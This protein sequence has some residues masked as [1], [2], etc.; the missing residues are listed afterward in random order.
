MTHTGIECFLAIC[1]HKTGN[2]AAQALFI[3]QPSL[4]A[5]LTV[6]EKE[7]GKQLFYRRKGSREMVLTP[8]GEEFYHLALQYEAVIDKM[9]NLG[10]SPQT[11]LRISCFNSLGTYL[12]P[13]V[14]Q[15]FLQTNPQISL[16]MQD[17][18]IVAASQSVLQGETD[19]AF[20]AGSISDSRL[21]QIPVFSEPMQVICSSA[22][23]LQTPA[24]L[25]ELPSQ[26]EVYVQWSHNFAQ[27]HQ[28]YLGDFHPQLCVSIMAQLRQFLEQKDRWAIVP[29]SVAKGLETECSI[30]Y[31][32][33]DLPLP[34]REVSYIINTQ[35][36]VPAGGAF[37]DCLRQVLM[38]YPEITVL[39]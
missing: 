30:R 13:A 14:Y 37:L 18:E 4:S 23:Q 10:Q 32:E 28:R 5:R 2:A 6:L 29:L 12:F 21:Q 19:L 1:R 27:W 16:Q 33:T 25:S 22:S 31:L 15:L 26:E 34:R 36:Q 9:H 24:T 20:T 3:T 35:S 38:T 7:V 17:M 8:A 11:T 39:L